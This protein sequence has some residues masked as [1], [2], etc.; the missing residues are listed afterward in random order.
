MLTKRIYELDSTRLITEAI[1]VGPTNLLKNWAALSP[2]IFE[3]LGVGGYNYAS[4][5]YEKDHQQFPDRIMV[6]TETFPMQSLENFTQAEKHSWVLGDFVWTAIDYIGEASVGNNEL[7]SRRSYK[8]SLSY[9]WFN[10]Y[11]GD[12]DLIGN[13]KPQSYYRDVVWRIKPIAMAVH[14]P[15][16]DGMFENVSAWGWP[17]EQQSWNWQGSENRPLQVRVFSRASA[18]RLYLNEKLFG[19]QTIPDGKI[20]TLFNVPY[21]PG[22]LKAVNIAN[23]KETDSIIF[24]T[25]GKPTHIKLVSDKKVVQADRNDLAFVMVEIRDDNGNLVPDAEVQ[26][27]FSISGSGEIAAVGNGNPTDMASF[28]NPERKTW[29]GNCLVIV[30]P[31]SNT[32]NITLKA[33]AVELK[34]AQIIISTKK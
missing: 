13:K 15:I 18:V 24:K 29:R 5:K 1:N 11:C 6:G 3:D 21:Q 27:N 7:A 16:P 32:G 31:N 26:V 33:S 14:A 2:A 10:A 12:I 9:P 20:V 25:T 4:F 17:D 22:V 30:R 34:P 8:G 28:Q 23:G 19:E